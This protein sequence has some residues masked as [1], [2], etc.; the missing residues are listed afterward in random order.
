MNE[1]T[2]YALLY[3]SWGLSIIPVQTNKRSLTNWKKQQKRILSEHAVRSLFSQ[4][5][6]AG[7]AIVCGEISGGL[8]VIDIDAK[9]DAT[10]TL[11]QRFGG[12]LRHQYPGILQKLVIAATRNN[13]YHFYFRCQNPGRCTVLARRPTTDTERLAD[14]YVNVKVLIETRAAGGYAI[15]YPTNGYRFIRGNLGCLQ[16]LTETEKDDLITLARSFN[17]IPDVKPS[18]HPYPPIRDRPGSPFADY[19]LRGNFQEVLINHGWRFVLS[20]NERIYF[21]RPGET[22]NA[23][24]GNYHH[25]RG[26]FTVFTPNTEFIPLKGYRPSAIY[27]ILECDG[28]FRL[29]AKRLID[30]GFGTPYSEMKG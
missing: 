23:V 4:P 21:R 8:L 13:G 10:A 18:P 14:P 29:A 12:R 24:S 22:Q 27:A 3:R 1:L 11:M 15:V 19:N 16:F 28:N 20:T 9:N 6:A 2:Q 7:I 25:N 30:A 26:L 5:L 17:L